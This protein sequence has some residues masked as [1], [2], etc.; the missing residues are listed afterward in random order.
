MNEY[1]DEYQRSNSRNAG[2][3]RIRDDRDKRYANQPSNYYQQTYGYDQYSYYQQQQYYETLRRT[4]PQAYA[5]LYKRYYGQ[6]PQ[7]TS[8]ADNAGTDCR[9]SVHSGRS[10][11]ADKDRY[12]FCVVVRM[13]NLCTRLRVTS[14]YE[15]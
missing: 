5:D 9:E 8:G 15:L 1:E 14:V 4:N 12:V 10:S 11:A 13:Q 6:L 2:G 3:E 7:Q